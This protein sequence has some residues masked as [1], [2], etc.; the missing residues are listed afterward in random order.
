[1]P[2][3]AKTV[4]TRDLELAIPLKDIEHKSS[5]VKFSDRRLSGYESRDDHPNSPLTGVGVFAG[6]EE[7]RS[8]PMASLT[9]TILLLCHNNNDWRRI[10]RVQSSAV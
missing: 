9:A 1:M 8:V 2:C 5:V 4:A 6:H 10:K 3:R 7:R